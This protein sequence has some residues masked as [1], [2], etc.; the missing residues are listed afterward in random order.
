MEQKEI[1]TKE[2]INAKAEA[3]GKEL[4]IKVFPILF[5]ES[6]DPTA[7]Q[8][9]GYIMEPSR[10]VKLRALDKSLMS[11]MSAA[12]ELLDIC[13][14]KEHSD[15][16]IYSEKSEHDKFYIGACMSAMDTIRHSVN[17]VKKK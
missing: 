5:Q 1:L 16:R 6:D 4:N 14:L 17:Q 11:Q 12:S 13:I 7:E 9:I 2:Q 10:M 15:P 3:L 8:I